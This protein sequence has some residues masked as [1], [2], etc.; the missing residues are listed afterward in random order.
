MKIKL[1]D[2]ILKEK[3]KDGKSYY[4][5]G[6]TYLFLAVI[7]YYLTL[8]IIFIKSLKPDADI[9]L[10]PLNVIIE[11][12]QWSMLL[13]GSY[14]FGNKGIDAVKAIMGTKEK[15]TTTEQPTNNG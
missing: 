15:Q 6:R 2:D 13:M 10:E 7:S 3:G 8:G 14:V 4:S 9:V 12:L 1:L 5:Q 11:A